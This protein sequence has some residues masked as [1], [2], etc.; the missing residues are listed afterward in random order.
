LEIYLRIRLRDKTK[1]SIKI[2]KEETKGRK[3]IQNSSS[4]IVKI[5]AQTNNNHKIISIIITKL[6]WN[7]WR[8]INNLNA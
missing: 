4:K 2:R 8:L 1:N 7:R 6:E 3:I 5:R